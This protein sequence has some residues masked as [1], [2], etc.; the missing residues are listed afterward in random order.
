MADKITV[1]CGLKQEEDGNM[2][3]TFSIT[4]LACIP[5]TLQSE[6]VQI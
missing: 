6:Q 1:S 3:T 2:K 4:G 5:W